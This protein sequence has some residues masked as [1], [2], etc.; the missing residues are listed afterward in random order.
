MGRIDHADPSLG[1]APRKPC[2]RCHQSQLTPGT[3]RCKGTHPVTVL[4]SIMQGMGWA[5]L[6]GK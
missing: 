4:P 3:K 1:N 6:A 2:P 5:G